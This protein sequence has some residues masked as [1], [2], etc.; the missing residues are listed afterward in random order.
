VA[1]FHVSLSVVA[2][3]VRSYPFALLLIVVLAAPAAAQDGPADSLVVA[4]EDP[5]TTRDIR[6][7]RAIY[8]A[9]GPVASA[10]MRGANWSSYKVFLTAAPALWL[11]T[12]A[13]DD[14]RDYEAAY[15]LTVTEA[16]T[17]GL[18]FALKNVV[19]RPRPYALVP[20]IEPRAR[21]H[22]GDKPFDPYSF[23]SGHAA[24]AFAIATSLSLSYPEWYVVAPSA[25]WAT[26]VSLSRSWLGVHY[27]TDIGIGAALGVGMAFG[28]GWTPCI[29]P[30]LGAILTYGFT[31]DTMWAGVGLLSVYS[32]G[33]AVPFLVTS[34]ALDS[35]LQAFKR[36]RRWI[37]VVE[38]ASGV[39]LILL[40]ILLLTGQFTVLSAYLTRFTPSFILERI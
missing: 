37:P 33:L 3:P 16:T 25:L 18:V 1:Y 10:T 5:P 31:Q 15:L 14:E 17:V 26:A 30:I 20:G 36:F 27:P 28:A 21:A 39:L 34:L 23:P 4:A 2:V 32:A 29:G 22:Q 13:F 40:G 19:Q 12:L 11:G 8:N 35:F 38:K 7:L 6:V 24:V 9:D